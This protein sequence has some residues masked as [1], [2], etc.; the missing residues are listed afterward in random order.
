[1]GMFAVNAFH[2][3]ATQ[4]ESEMLR[5]QAYASPVRPFS[6][7]MLVS[8]ERPIRILKRPG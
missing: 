1:M 2:D 8:L 4:P 6:A 7:F 3:L 5:C